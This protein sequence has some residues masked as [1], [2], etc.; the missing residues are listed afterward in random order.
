MPTKT[1]GPMRRSNLKPP[2]A[3][4]VG[5][6][7]I[8]SAL[9]QSAQPPATHEP[10]TRRFGGMQ[11]SSHYVKM[12][13]GV[14]LAVDVHIPTGLKPGERT[15]TILHMSRY[16]R[17][18]DIK[19]LWRPLFG[20]GF[21][22]VTERD[23]REQMVKA[24]YS[25]VD[26]DVRGTGASF[27]KWEYP[28]SPE[29][30]RDGSDVID[31]IV[32]QPWS[33]GIVGATGGSYNASLAIM[34]LANDHPA[35]K[36]V[37]TRF[38]AWDMYEDVFLPGGLPAT[39]FR[40]S[41]SKLVAAFDQNELGGVFGWAAGGMVRGVR[42]V[43]AKLLASAQASR[44]NN[45]NLDF[46]IKPLVFRDDPTTPGRPWTSEH[47]SPY[48]VVGTS[49]KVPV[50]SYTGWFDG[51]MVRGQIHQFEATRAPGSR[52]KIGPWFHADFSN[53]SP[54][55]ERAD[56]PDPADDVQEFFDEHLRGIKPRV[57]KLAIEYFSMGAEVWRTA[58]EWPPATSESQYLYFSDS[59]T[60]TP[61]V[62][63]TPDASDRHQ[64]DPAFESGA[65]RW[66]VAA[67]SGRSR[68][69]GD[70]R[71][72]SARL[73]T[74]TSAPIERPLE[75]VGNPRVEIHLSANRQDGG[76]FVYLEDVAPDGRIRYVTEG[77]LRLLHRAE[78]RT[79]R[80]ADAK[81]MIPGTAEKVTVDLLPTAYRFPAGHAIRIAIGGADAGTFD[82]V[83]ASGALY[84][85]H[86]GQLHQSRVRLPVL[87]P[88]R[89][90]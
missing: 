88:R 57:E 42:P 78:R 45:T 52:L 17:S 5:I 87:G 63:K 73:L 58:N 39:S 71:G 56:W 54:Y 34:L 60:L 35:L 59:K 8:A 40:E 82:V 6:W 77:Q 27:G 26:V 24:G 75:V 61:F 89:S 3:L 16:Y 31:W 72:Y 53:A 1:A 47:F 19:T 70:R 23:T 14:R 66:G 15:A 43:D 4:I 10:T 25:W 76:L 65:A 20:A 33:A 79:F 80:R 7:L 2:I 51:A 18:L 22:T 13:D 46:L 81:P 55:A 48:S 85:L 50:F 11:E 68:K 29:E 69:Y 64:V 12:R 67:G 83:D 44:G 74:Y 36:A 84:I 38:G 32:Q 41:Y 86:H 30:V 62:S 49:T 28:L 37:V 21:Y 90:R 9:S